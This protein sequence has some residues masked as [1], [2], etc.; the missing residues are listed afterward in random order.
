MVGEE[1]GR[2]GEGRGRH[3]HRERPLV[4]ARSRN[5]RGGREEG[6][7]RGGFEWWVF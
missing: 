1:G 2:G 6:E 7:G 3:G 5:P 4:L